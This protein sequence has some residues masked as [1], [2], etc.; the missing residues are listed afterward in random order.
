VDTF[1]NDVEAAEAARAELARTV[2]AEHARDVA[3]MQAQ[4]A[5]ADAAHDPADGAILTIS[6]F[7][8]S[9]TVGVYTE[10]DAKAQGHDTRHFARLNPVTVSTP[11]PSRMVTKAPRA[12]ARA[13]RKRRVVG[14][15][16]RA[17]SPGRQ[18]D[19]PELAEDRRCKAPGCDRSLVGRYKQTKTCSPACRKA[20]SRSETATPSDATLEVHRIAV[21]LVQEGKLRGWEAL[22]LVIWPTPAVLAALAESRVA[23]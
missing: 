1:E 16:A 14:A 22:E 11:K 19:D 2:R 17:R 3:A 12:R 21:R 18:S 10:S 13:P 8:G 7:A 23:A 6:G 15:A 5:A 4:I 9:G 20:L